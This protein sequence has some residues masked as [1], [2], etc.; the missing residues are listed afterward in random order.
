[1]KPEKVRDLLYKKGLIPC[2]TKS[3]YLVSCFFHGETNGESLSINFEKQCRD[4][5]IGMFKCFSPK[6][7]GKSGT[8][9]KLLN[10]IGMKSM[11]TDYNYCCD[12]K[13]PEK[14]EEAQVPFSYQ[15]FVKYHDKLNNNYGIKYL[16]DRGI[17]KDISII[18][19]ITYNDF[20]KRVYI[21]FWQN[22]EI[23]GIIGRS[24]YSNDEYQQLLD[25]IHEKYPVLNHKLIDKYIREG[26]FREDFPILNRHAPHIR[27]INNKGLLKENYVFQPISNTFD[28]PYFLVEGQIDALKLNTFGYNALAILGSYPSEIQLR[29]IFSLLKNKDDLILCFDNDKAGENNNKILNK[30]SIHQFKSINFNHCDY[31]VKD[32]G[33]IKNKKDFEKILKKSL[34][35]FWYDD[36]IIN[37]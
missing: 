19:H 4:G 8:L 31:K 25:K 24:V 23:E 12:H 36:N 33:D 35:S 3:Q 22:Q 18:N 27:Y 21:P 10:L 28:T 26:E 15:D 7:K 14:V 13:E 11:I 20:F 30:S 17:D 16:E 5:S 9:K 1:M 2:N 6:C 29:Y 37:V 32:V 34:T